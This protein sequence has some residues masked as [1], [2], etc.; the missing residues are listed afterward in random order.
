M[1]EK[2]FLELL[3]AKGMEIP[4]GIAKR[5]KNVAY[6]PSRKEIDDFEAEYYR[7]LR[8]SFGRPNFIEIIIGKYV[9]F[10]P[11]LQKFIRRM[12]LTNF[13]NFVTKSVEK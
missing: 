3:R 7:R 8:D 10:S 12:R 1:L 5:Y 9:V 4:S 2:R 11:L 13:R 6:F